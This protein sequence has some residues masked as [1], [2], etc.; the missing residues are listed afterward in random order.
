MNRRHPVQW[1][2]FGVV[3]LGVLA[4]ALS[5]LALRG[6]ATVPNAGATPTLPATPTSGAPSPGPSG[7][8]PTPS[9]APSASATSDGSLGTGLRGRVQPPLTVAG[10]LA[11]RATTGTCTGGAPSTVL[12]TTDAGRTWGPVGA[13]ASAVLTLA[14]GAGQL[15]AVAAAAPGITGGGDCT[16]GRYVLNGPRSWHGPQAAATSWYREPNDPTKVHT[17]AGDVLNPCRDRSVPVVE[18]AGFGPQDATVLCADGDVFRTRDSGNQWARLSVV[19]DALALAWE[20]RSLGWLVVAKSHGCAGLAA[21][22]TLD[23]GITWQRVGCLGS[24]PGLLA[25]RM[26]VA[27]DFDGPERGMAVVGDHVFTTRDGG[28]SWQA[29]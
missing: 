6:S 19:H 26:P 12:R 18:L 11:Y 20:S 28:L 9:L 24:L 10:K 23:G 2:T 25:R 29:A 8:T 7:S 13:P 21:A 27:V 15:V 22:R 5:F 17:P 14:A 4:L 16:P 1:A 3:V